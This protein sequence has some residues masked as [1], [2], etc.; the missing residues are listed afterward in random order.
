MLKKV[1]TLFD[2]SLAD[3]FRRNLPILT[4]KGFLIIQQILP[5]LIA[6]RA[7]EL[8]CEQTRLSFEDVLEGR[9]PGVEPALIEALLIAKKAGIHKMETYV[10]AEQV[11]RYYGDEFQCIVRCYRKNCATC[12]FAWELSFYP[13]GRLVSTNILRG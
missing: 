5:G 10:R 4:S 12:V 6:F 8:E 3:A 9:F 1:N 13:I 11:I 7:L 2:P